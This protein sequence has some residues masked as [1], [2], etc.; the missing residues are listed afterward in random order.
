MANQDGLS[1]YVEAAEALG[2]GD[3]GPGG[4]VRP[5][6]LHRDRRA[7][8]RHPGVGGRPRRPEPQGDRGVRGRGAQRDLDAA[9]RAGRRLGGRPG[10][11]W[12]TSCA[13]RARRAAG[14]LDGHRHPRRG[15]VQGGGLRR[16]DGQEGRSGGQGRDGQGQEGHHQEGPGQ[17]GPGQEGHR[18][19]GH[20][21]RRPRPPRPRRPPAKKAPA[22]KAPAKKAPAKKAPAKKAPAK[23]APAKKSA[24]PAAP[25]GQS[26]SRVGQLTKSARRRL[27]LELVRRGLVQNRQQAQ[28]AVAGGTGAG[29]RCGGRQAG[30]PGG[31]RPSRSRPPGDG[32]ALRQPRRRE[33]RRAPSTGS[34]SRWTGRRALDAGAST[35]GFTDC[36]LQRGAARVFAVDVGYGQLDARLRSDPRVVVPRADQ[37]PDCSPGRLWRPATPL[38]PGRPGDGRP[39]L[40]LPHRGGAGPGRAGAAARGPTWCCWSSRSSR[41]GGPRR[42]GGKG[43]IRDPQLWRQ[44]LDRVASALEAAGAGIMGAM[45]RRWPAPA[46]NTEFLLHAAARRP[47][48]DADPGRR[49]WLDV[50]VAEGQ[51]SGPPGGARRWPPWPCWSTG[52]PEA[53]EAL[54]LPSR[55]LAGSRA[56]GP[57]SLQ[58]GTDGR[59]GRRGGPAG[60]PRCRSGGHRLAVSLGGD[61]TFLAWSPWPGRPGSRCSGSTSAGWAT[62]RGGAR[63]PGRA[64]SSASWP[65]DYDVEDRMVMAVTVEATSPR[66][67]TERPGRDRG[68]GRRRGRRMHLDGPERDGGRED[69]ARP[70]GAPG[71]RPSTASPSSPTRPTA[72]WWPPRPVRRPTT[73]RPAARSCPRGCA[74]HGRHAGGPPPGHRPQPG[75]G[76]PTRW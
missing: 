21:P 32:P 31:A 10:R 40:H 41:P 56:T 7:A 47:G 46:G 53:A 44:A 6:D 70:H 33:A 73:C 36:L 4:G 5:R 9:R 69:G 55:G 67:A 28:A 15:S 71:A 27:D 62:S 63:R 20:A 50:A 19:E 45:A 35:G 66:P 17:E 54:A 74:A 61:G 30:A 58:L 72:C 39:V 59:S 24:A 64:R 22:K 8:R 11:G 13:D 48:G 26:A 29:R 16:A 76:R 52:R 25:P 51:A 65:E 2:P 57:G 49:T 68:D 37:H 3:P 23:K 38:R 75:P 42:L 18:Q 14:H 12:P 43:V 34:A 1:K 60:S